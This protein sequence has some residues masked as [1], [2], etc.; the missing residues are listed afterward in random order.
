MDQRVMP[1][2]RDLS[3]DPSLA[4]QARLGAILARVATFLAKKNT[5][6]AFLHNYIFVTSPELYYEG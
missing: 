6:H 4:F 2:D 3:M 5:G 1:M